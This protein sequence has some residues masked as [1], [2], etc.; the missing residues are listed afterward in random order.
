MVQD[1]DTLEIT[2]SDLYRTSNAPTLP[3]TEEIRTMMLSTGN[4]VNWRLLLTT[5]TNLIFVNGPAN[6]ASPQSGKE[7]NVS[8]GTM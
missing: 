7:T 5:L 6:K 8:S 4:S 2:Y 1:Q 3:Q